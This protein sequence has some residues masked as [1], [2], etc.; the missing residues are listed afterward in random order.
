MFQKL[1]RRPRAEDSRRENIAG[2]GSAPN[3]GAFCKAAPI[4]APGGSRQKN[5]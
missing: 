3:C 1:Y 2:G 4:F 5:E